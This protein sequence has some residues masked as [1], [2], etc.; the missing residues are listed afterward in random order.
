VP[1]AKYKITAVEVGP[2]KYIKLPDRAP[3]IC[4]D[5]LSRRSF[6]RSDTNRMLILHQS[7]FK[8]T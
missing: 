7:H 8:K 6:V 1:K 3:S 5:L 2:V 4:C